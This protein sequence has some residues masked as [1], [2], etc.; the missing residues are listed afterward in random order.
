[1]SAMDAVKIH[2]GQKKTDSEWYFVDTR[3]VREILVEYPGE[4]EQKNIKIWKLD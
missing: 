4:I 2:G 3:N 1:M